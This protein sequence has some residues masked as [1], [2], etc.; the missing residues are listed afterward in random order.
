MTPEQFAP[1]AF[2]LTIWAGVITAFA[3]LMLVLT[4]RD[5]RMSDEDFLKHNIFGWRDID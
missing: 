4:I 2:V 3:F 1:I 5:S